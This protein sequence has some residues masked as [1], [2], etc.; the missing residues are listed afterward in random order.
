MTNDTIELEGVIDLHVHAGPDVRA[1]KQSALALALAARDAGWRGFLFKNHHAPTVVAAGLLKEAVPELAIFGGLALNESVGGLN[2][3]AVEAAL[4]MG[5]KQIWMPTLDAAHERAFRGQPGAGITVFDEAGELCGAVHEILRL[6]AASDCIL[7][8]GHLSP[9]EMA[10][11]VRAGREAG[12][13]KL[14]VNH[15]EINFLNLAPA[16]Q[17]E[18]AAQGVWFERCF[19][20][21]NQAVNWDGLAAV[22]REIGIASTVLATDLGQPDNVDPIAGMKQMI[23]ELSHRGFTRDELTTMTRRNPAVLLG[24]S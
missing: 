13:A 10:A 24:L 11:V 21:A 6:I 5:A 17:R 14:L 22:I 4:K 7:G 3:A 18:L 1:R 15:P 16:A 20:R 12:V 8:L 23:A 9:A 19:V 2:P